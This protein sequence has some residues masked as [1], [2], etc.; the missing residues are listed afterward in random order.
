MPVSDERDEDQNK[1]WYIPHHCTKGKFRIIFD[2]AG[3]FGGTSLNKQILQGP[4][5]ANNLIGVLTRF[6]KHSV[7]VVGDIR[8]MLHSVM[9]DR[10]DR[11]ALRFF[12]WED[13]DTLRPPTAYKLTVHC[14]GLTSSPSVAGFA[15]RKTAEENRSN[16]MPEAVQTAERNMYVDDLLKSVPDSD[17]AI[18]HI[19]DVVSLLKGGRFELRKFSSNCA[20]V[21]EALPSDLLAPHLSEVD[22]HNNELPG[23]KTLGILW[24]PQTDEFMVKVKSFA[25][26][27]TRRGLLSL[28]MSIF[29][30]LGIVASFL[31]PLK[32]LI[33]RLTKMGLA[34]DAEI[35]EPDKTVC[36]KLINTLLNLNDIVIPRCLYPLKM[37]K[38]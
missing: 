37:L 7:A 6:R 28:A 27:L 12:W 31:L 2:C 26:P 11:S 10:C 29:D 3:Q 35:P 22:L 16:S 17:S 36:N 4:D 14:F 33:Q 8:A 18:T 30:P 20:K 38:L 9:V 5:N 24:N 15:L 34:W 1:T 23:H 21:L 25:H 32:L 19:N 13:D